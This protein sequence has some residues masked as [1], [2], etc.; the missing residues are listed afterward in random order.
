VVL[1]KAS[2]SGRSVFPKRPWLSHGSAEAPQDDFPSAPTTRRSSRSIPSPPS[3]IAPKRILPSR[4]GTVV[5]TALDLYSDHL[6]YQH[7]ASP[8]A[9]AP[10]SHPETCSASQSGLYILQAPGKP[11]GVP[12][13][14]PEWLPPR[15]C[16]VKVPTI[17]PASDAVS[18]ALSAF[19]RKHQNHN[20]W[21]RVS[22]SMYHPLGP[23]CPGWRVDG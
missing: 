19:S 7:A 17:R 23:V 9:C 8:T 10:A 14:P 15:K 5:Y 3:M 12:L 6:L 4:S 11:T 21:T 18:P 2:L 22:L 16:A 20:L 1:A 13:I